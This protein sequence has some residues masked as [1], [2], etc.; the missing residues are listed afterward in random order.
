MSTTETMTS[1]HK[2][3]E[4]V[5]EDVWQRAYKGD[6]VK[7]ISRELNIPS[8]TTYKLV[9]RAVKAFG[10][11]PEI[12]HGVKRHL[13]LGTIQFYLNDEFSYQKE[14]EGVRNR[15]NLITEFE[16]KI[17]PLMGKNNKIHYVIVPKL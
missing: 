7:R 17:F 4:D 9:R 2:Y 10:V 6:P 16:N 5:L 11:I 13:V 8:S 12:N 3:G 1:L 14:Y 15:N